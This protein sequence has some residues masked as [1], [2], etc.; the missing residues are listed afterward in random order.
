LTSWAV[1]NQVLKKRLDK[2]VSFLLYYSYSERKA[3]EVEI[4]FLCFFSEWKSDG[5]IS[6]SENLTAMCEWAI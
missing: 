3:V 6:L 1:E 4:N 5:E 2:S